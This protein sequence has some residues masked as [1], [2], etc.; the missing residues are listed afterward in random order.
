MCIRD[1]IGVIL[2]IVFVVSFVGCIKFFGSWNHFGVFWFY[3]GLLVT[4]GGILCVRVA[5]V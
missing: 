4:S 2:T 5:E 3:A 1:Y